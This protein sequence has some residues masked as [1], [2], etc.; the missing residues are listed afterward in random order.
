LV[1]QRDHLI[2]GVKDYNELSGERQGDGKEEERN[3]A[4]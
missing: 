1:D 2:A 4:D 3:G